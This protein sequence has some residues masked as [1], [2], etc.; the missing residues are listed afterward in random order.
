MN[1]LL[2]LALVFGCLTAGAAERQIAV[3]TDPV[4]DDH[5]DGTLIYPQRD[6]FQRGDMDLTSLRIARDGEFYRFEATFRNP[7][8]NPLN[9]GGDVGAESFASFARRGFY[10]F[11]LDIYVD[12]DRVPGSGNVFTLPGRQASIDPANAWERAVVLTPRPELMRQQLISALTDSNAGLDKVQ[13]GAR[14]DREILFVTDVRV[15]NRVVSFMVPAAFLAS[16]APEQQWS[17]V[18]LVTGA[19]LAI[20][21]DINLFG[22][23]RAPLERLALGAMQTETGRPRDGFGYTGARAPAPIVDLLGTAPGVQEALLRSG[24]PLTGV[25]LG[26]APA[27][28]AAARASPVTSLLAVATPPAAPQLAPAGAPAPA[29]AQAA[30][31][32]VPVPS[33]GQAATQSAPAPAA[34]TAAAPIGAAAAPAGATAPAP[35]VPAPPAAAASPGPAAPVAGTATDRPAAAAPAPPRA[36]AP[37]ASP[38]PAPVSAAAAERLRVLK[39]LFDKKLID[40]AEYKQIRQRIL[41][42]L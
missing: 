6:E 18:V 11:N 35:T 1:R 9:V 15:R 5:G 19:K 42:E 10:S 34:A 39:D 40:E 21:A 36:T 23:T 30:K 32:A 20:E 12:Q 33:A 26:P 3:L 2:L 29:A 41:S 25:A 17:M 14:I 8:R 38:A 7:V 31:P 13:A 16:P 27:E 37:V 4:G 22:S 28:A 24:A